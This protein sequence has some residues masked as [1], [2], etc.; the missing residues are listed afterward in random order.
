MIVDCD[1]EI[2]KL[3]QTIENHGRP[4]E[5]PFTRPAPKTQ[6]KRSHDPNFDLASYMERILGTDLTQIEG[7]RA[8][9][10]H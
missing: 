1:R 5:T 7:I 3:L 9:D 6:K 8:T 10:L 2:E 4:P